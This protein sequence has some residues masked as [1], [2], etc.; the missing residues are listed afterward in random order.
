M[1][2]V[3]AGGLLL[4]RGGGGGSRCKACT[5]A[6]DSREVAAGLLEGGAS[7]LFGGDGWPGVGVRELV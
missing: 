7:A 3:L 1:E 5:V 4:I 6:R 2:E